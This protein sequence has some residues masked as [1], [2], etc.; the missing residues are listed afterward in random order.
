MVSGLAPVR[1]GQFGAGALEV[2]VVDVGYV[3]LMPC[4]PA[5]GDHGHRKQEC[6]AVP[7]AQCPGA[8]SA[9]PED[10]PIHV[11]LRRKQVTQHNAEGLQLQGVVGTNQLPIQYAL[12]RSQISVW[13]TCQLSPQLIGPRLNI[14]PLCG[15][16]LFVD[17]AQGIDPPVSGFRRDEGTLRTDRCPNK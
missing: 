14:G 2:A 17:R 1:A 16:E 13:L 3:T 12:Q 4:F 7:V 10:H 15:H 6:L 5:S 9:I 8:P 11:K